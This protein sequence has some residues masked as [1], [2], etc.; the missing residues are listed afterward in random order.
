[1]E[2]H[3]YGRLTTLNKLKSVRDNPLK[4]KFQRNQADKAMH[5][6]QAQLK[7]RKLMSLR[8]QLIKATRAG[9]LHTVW[10]I[11]NT[12]KDYEKN[13]QGIEHEQ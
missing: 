7:D 13:Y 1:M 12:I 4:P 8:E 6:I 3:L 5:K 9:D 2:D 11:E 10:K